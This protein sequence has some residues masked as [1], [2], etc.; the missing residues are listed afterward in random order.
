[1]CIRDRGYGVYVGWLLREGEARPLKLLPAGGAEPAY[2]LAMRAL[3]AE[4]ARDGRGERVCVGASKASALVP[5]AVV[6][7]LAVPAAILLASE[8]VAWWEWV[9][10]A[11]GLA[12][13]FAFLAWY[14]AARLWPRPLTEEAQL[15]RY[16]PPLRSR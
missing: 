6:I 1:M 9:L 13:M 12:A 4:L 15:N 10:A 3:A 2:G 16:L 7:L 11:A 14:A 5:P 8:R